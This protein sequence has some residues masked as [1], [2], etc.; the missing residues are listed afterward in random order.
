M[1]TNEKM[2]AINEKVEVLNSELNE[3]NEKELEQ[4]SGGS[5]DVITNI[6]MDQIE[7]ND[8]KPNSREYLNSTSAN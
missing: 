1:K 3:L 2:N 8:F 7:L 5:N 4:V 6:V